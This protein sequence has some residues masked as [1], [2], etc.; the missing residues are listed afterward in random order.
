MLAFNI[1]ILVISF[2]MMEFV[3]WFTHKY[4]MHGV[5][6]N[7]HRD[8]HQKDQAKFFEHND[9]FFLLFATPG[10]LLIYLG[11]MYD[12]LDLCLWIGAG[13]SLYG[14]CYSLVHDIFIHQRFKVLT[15]TNNVYLK[16]IRKAHK[17]HHKHFGKY[18]G[19]CFG[20]LWAP[21]QYLSEVKRV[22][23]KS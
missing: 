20:M 23:S 16:A 12:T 14:L 19:E 15:K 21:W 10:I 17:I 13:I 9:F 5:L 1:L 3:A 4:I 8:H 6:W 2:F 18:D 22:M 7:L 11:T